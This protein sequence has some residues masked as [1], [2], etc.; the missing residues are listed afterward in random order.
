MRASDLSISWR[1]YSIFAIA[2]LPFLYFATNQIFVSYHQYNESLAVD[3]LAQFS[4]FVSDLVHELQMERG[5]SAVYIGSK[6]KRFSEELNKQGNITDAAIA[7]L[8]TELEAR[9]LGAIDQQLGQLSKAGLAELSKL[10]SMRKGVRTLETDVPVM[11]KFYTTT[12]HALLEIVERVAA[13]THDGDLT[14]SIFAYIAVLEGKERAGIERTMGAG[15]FAAGEFSQSVYLRFVEMAAE[16]D[17]LFKIAAEYASAEERRFMNEVFAAPIMTQVSDARRIGY[18][19]QFG[20]DI[21]SVSGPDWFEMSTKRIDLLKTV[22]DKFAVDLEHQAA[23]KE[24]SAATNLIVVSVVVVLV[25]AVGFVVSFLMVRSITLPIRDLVSGA[26]RLSSGDINVEFSAVGR[27]DEI[28]RIADS[29]AQF[30]DN[31]AEQKQLQLEQQEERKREHLRQNH[32]DGLVKK[33][34]KTISDVVLTMNAENEK[35]RSSAGQLTSAAES[36][37]GAASHAGQATSNANANVQ[38]VAAAAEELSA[39]ISEI[40]GQSQRARTIVGQAADIARQTDKDV[41]GLAEAA[42]N[43]GTVVEMIRTI[44]EQTNLLALNA[45]IEAARAGDA[46]K[47][48]AVVAQ[49]VKDLSHQTGKATEEIAEQIDAVQAST[50]NAVSAIQ[51]ISKSIMDVTDVTEVISEAVEQQNMATGEISQ[52]IALASDGSTQAASNVEYVADAIGQTRS[53]VDQV[54]AISSQLADVAQ[55]LT[56][57][58]EEFLDEVAK[59]VDER[60]QDSRKASEEKATLVISGRSIDTVIRNINADGVKVDAVEGMVVG[61]PLVIESS[62]VRRVSALVIWME[63]GSAGLKFRREVKVAA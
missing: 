27:K 15:G 37:D 61:E 30:R 34:R 18:A 49:E 16:Q 33:F 14:R 38:T 40:A 60:R 62:S 5:E 4:P 39:S 36:A 42:A 41:S 44:A 53:Q 59:D 7:N 2:I 46:G 55:L 35:M 24:A 29:V 6:G 48:F 51:A 45:T 1:I 26:E 12:I 23:A 50:D 58:V 21:S 43:I 31:V 20:G 9:D 13:L 54:H 57:S 28:G 25:I 19:S 8:K 56:G 17:T 47:G 32:L 22:E 10:D 52:S 11:A 63:D 3:K